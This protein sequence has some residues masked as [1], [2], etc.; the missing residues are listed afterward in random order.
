MT[1]NQSKFL[2]M[3]VNLNHIL[4]RGIE[5]VVKEYIP[6]MSE[7]APEVF[8]QNNNGVQFEEDVFIETPTQ[9]TIKLSTAF[10]TG[11]ADVVVTGYCACED[12]EEDD[13]CDDEKSYQGDQALF[14]IDFTM[15]ET[16]YI[17]ECL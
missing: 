1:P 6:Y 13:L 5:S 2:D 9:G 7:Y 8:S 12:Q 3:K 10:L 15:P 16:N 14:R 11:G 17:N 4:I